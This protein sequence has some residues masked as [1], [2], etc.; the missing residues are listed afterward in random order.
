MSFLSYSAIHQP[1]A[2][3]ICTA[4]P[5]A[6]IPQSTPMCRYT[7]TDYLRCAH[8]VGPLIRRC[9]SR[10]RVLQ[11][12]AQRLERGQRVTCPLRRCPVREDQRVDVEGFCPDCAGGVGAEEA[13]GLARGDECEEEGWGV[14]RE[15]DEG[16]GDVVG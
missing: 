12:R 4:T 2:F 7:F 16:E 3:Q 8:G 9:P 11:R 6:Q 5:P 13:L 10:R 15:G 1:K 14:E